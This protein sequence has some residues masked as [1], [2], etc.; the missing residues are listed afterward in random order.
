MPKIRKTLA[1]VATLTLAAGLYGVSSVVDASAA[2]P[3]CGPMCLEV[4]SPQFGTADNPRFVETVLN[5]REEIGAP[6]V[7]GPAS[8]TNTASDI[9][10]HLNKVS[11]FYAAGMV[12]AAV[13]A[14]YGS[15]FAAQLEY[16]PAGDAT[17][18]CVGLAHPAYENES[19]S[20]QSCT[21]PGSTVFIVDSPDAPAATPT[22]TP[23][24]IGSTTNFV[25]PWTMVYN[26]KPTDQPT[27]RIRVSRLQRTAAGAV[28]IDQLFGTD[29]G[30]LNQTNGEPQKPTIVLVHGAWADSSSW[31]GEIARLQYDGY[32]VVAA[33]NPLRG[34]SSDSAT[35]ADF[36]AKISG[37]IVLVGHS[38]GGAVI[39]D[40]GTGNPNVKALVYDDA[41]IP[42]Q[43]ENIT[44]LSTSASALA[45]AATKPT[46]VFKLVPDPGA[47]AGVADTYLLPDVF[48]T[49]F[50]TDV[51]HSQAAVLEAEQSP[52][53]LVALAEPLSTTPAWQT[54]PS[55][56]IVGTQDKIIPE[57]AQLSM[58]KR[59]NAHVTLVKSSHV[60]LISHPG[61]VTSVIETAAKATG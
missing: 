28:P 59:A 37:P 44:T 23:L 51:P 27:P 47:P 45:P 43:G 1:T 32:P 13:N 58:A 15:L 4:F 22:Y 53:S 29:H 56:D 61:L 34:L 49:D 26:G 10:P 48:F 25:H 41:Y 6:M 8:N 54:I 19:L 46:S 24:I 50:A 40:A 3:A 38:Y 42:A 16:A 7:L 5:G 12:S 55:W 30:V 60:S 18:L 39:T 57:A 36:L 14:H 17:G 20:L 11:G 33:P 52:T 35:L 31:S 2:T 9:V 21:I